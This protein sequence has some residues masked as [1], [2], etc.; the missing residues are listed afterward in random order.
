[1]AKQ[2]LVTLPLI[3]LLMDYCPLD[4]VFP[5]REDNEAYSPG[6]K[7][8]VGEKVPLL[9][10]AATAALVTLRAQDSGGALSHGDAGS[11][12]MNF[13][14]GLLS[15]V[16][17]IRN[18]FWPVDLAVFYPLELASVTPFKVAGAVALI[19]AIT[20]LALLQR[21]QRPYLIFG[22]SWYLITLLPV[23]GFV[24]I[25]SQ[26]M[27][28]RYTY[29]PL[30]GL[31]IA[32]AWGGAEIAGRWRN[33]L[34]AAAGVAAATLAVLS[35]L[36]VAQLRIWHNSYDLYSHSLT[37]VERN[38]L[39]HNN[40]GILLAQQ[41]RTG[42][43]INHFRESLRIFPNQVGGYQN[44][45]N[46]YQAVGDNGAAIEAFREALRL[47]PNDVESHFRLGYAYLLAG[48]LDLAYKE[49][50][51]LRRLDES[52]ARPLLDSIELRKRR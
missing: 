6:V 9:I 12:M 13:G 22:W 34:P 1:M 51:V 52:Q 40:M 32:V 25:G 31:F 33:G 23:I 14:N 5:R 37:V 35:M 36:T 30:I 39:A 10:M 17:Y 38:W 7:V 44:L 47:D 19:A 11:I 20:C 46:A 41:N 16:K 28:D 24:R 27:A 29:I 50:L 48:N 8:I 15:Y 49:Y 4:R 3:L 43:A 18:M 45:G 42:E 26:A 2:M 21:R